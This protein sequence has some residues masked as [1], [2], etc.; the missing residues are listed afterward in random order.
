ML[1][2]LLVAWGLY[3][4]VQTWH[5]AV[6]GLILLMAL[7]FGAAYLYDLRHCNKQMGWRPDNRDDD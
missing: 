5:L 4:P 7:L 3:W 6:L 1:H 2:N